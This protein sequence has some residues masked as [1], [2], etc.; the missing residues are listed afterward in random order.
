MFPEYNPEYNPEC[1]PE[2]LAD[3]AERI[4]AEGGC[5]ALPCPYEKFVIKYTERNDG[6]F[7]VK[8]SLERDRYQNALLYDGVLLQATVREPIKPGLGFSSALLSACIL[9][10]Y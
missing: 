1:I 8:G 2:Y 5:T 10:L 7:D 4:C 9:N 6:L 3:C